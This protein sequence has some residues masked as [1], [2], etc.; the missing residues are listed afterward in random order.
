MISGNVQEDLQY[1]LSLIRKSLDITEYPKI[2]FTLS[3]KVIL[4][5]VISEVYNQ[6]NLGDKQIVPSL[7]AFHIFFNIYGISPK[8]LEEEVD[9]LQFK[10]DFRR[11]R[12]LL[13]SP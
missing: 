12:E 13:I 10:I 11:Y 3:E 1:A 4:R 2:E 5:K 8:P 7:E 9:S 6:R